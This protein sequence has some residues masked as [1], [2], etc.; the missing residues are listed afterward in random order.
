MVFQANESSSLRQKEILKVEGT[1]SAKC[2]GDVCSVKAVSPPLGIG[3][4]SYQAIHST[5]SEG[6]KPAGRRTIRSA[7]STRRRIV[8]L[9][10]RP[11]RT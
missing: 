2:Q 7:K 3:L 9:G 5:K 8:G 10:T 11:H 1:N 6:K 4:G